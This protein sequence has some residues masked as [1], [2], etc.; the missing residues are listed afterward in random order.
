MINQHIAACVAD[1]RPINVDHV[2]INKMVS[3]DSLHEIP[4]QS[5]PTNYQWFVDIV[6]NTGRWVIDFLLIDYLTMLRSLN[7]G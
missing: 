3:L 5:A 4:L 7:V 2:E 6:L 1:I